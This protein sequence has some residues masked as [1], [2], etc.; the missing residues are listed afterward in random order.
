[1]NHS[2]FCVF[3][4]KMVSESKPTSRWTGSATAKSMKI[5]EFFSFMKLVH[6]VEILLVAHFKFF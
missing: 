1:M 6:S 4:G 2:L 5:R 3:I